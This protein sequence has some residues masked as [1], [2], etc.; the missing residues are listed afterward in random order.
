[1]SHADAE[2]SRVFHFIFISTWRI[3]VNDW[4][5]Y[6]SASC[7]TK[8]NKCRYFPNSSAR[9][10]GLDPSST[11]MSLSFLYCTTMSEPPYIALIVRIPSG[12]PCRR[13]L[14]HRVDHLVRRSLHPDAATAQGDTARSP[15]RHL[16]VHGRDLADRSAVRRSIRDA[17]HAVQELSW[18]QLR[19][20]GKCLPGRLW[21]LVV[22]DSI[23]SEKALTIDASR[24]AQTPV[25]CASLSVA[26]KMFYWQAFCTRACFDYLLPQI[27]TVVVLRKTLVSQCLITLRRFS[28]IHG[29]RKGAVSPWVLKFDI[30]LLTF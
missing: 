25:A 2:Q 17:F 4:T 18:L 28:C 1:M 10:T 9:P 19:E 11:T 20:D 6:V 24:W 26:P 27:S 12:F 13:K 30:S 15:V 8:W 3:I 21:L 7:Q 16:P 22:Q 29:L 14:V 5:L 23:S